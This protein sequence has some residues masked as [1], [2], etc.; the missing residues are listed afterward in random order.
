MVISVSFLMKIN[1]I[2]TAMSLF[3]ELLWFIFLKLQ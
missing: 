2:I 3:F 1:F